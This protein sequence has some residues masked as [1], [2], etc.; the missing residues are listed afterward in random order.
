M[1]EQ[2]SL[3]TEDAKLG[4]TVNPSVGV[5]EDVKET[6]VDRDVLDEPTSHDSSQFVSPESTTYSAYEQSINYCLKPIQVCGAWSEFTKTITK[7]CK[8]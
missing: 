7:G 6:C 1:E 8:W 3:H 5:D 4:D 2:V